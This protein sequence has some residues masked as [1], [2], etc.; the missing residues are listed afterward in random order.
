VCNLARYISTL[1][2]ICPKN[3]INVRG[4]NPK[5]AQSLQG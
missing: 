1:C 3:N 2:T 5:E 4:M